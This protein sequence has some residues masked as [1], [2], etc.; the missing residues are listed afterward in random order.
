[1]SERLNEWERRRDGQRNQAT[2]AE[3]FAGRDHCGENPAGCARAG[4]IDRHPRQPGCRIAEHRERR[5]HQRIERR[6]PPRCDGVAEINVVIAHDLLL[7][8]ANFVQI[9]QRGRSTLADERAGGVKR[10]EVVPG[11]PEGDGFLRGHKCIADRQRRDEQRKPAGPS[12]EAMAQQGRATL[13]Q[14]GVDLFI[15]GNGRQKS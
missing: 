9:V 13:R 15:I 12:P 14:V 3:A 8:R 5:E 10:K 6:I 2:C 4:D 7:E 1:M 11:R